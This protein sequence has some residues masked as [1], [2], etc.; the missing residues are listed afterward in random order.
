MNHTLFI[1][2]N[3]CFVIV[4]VLAQLRGL[5]HPAAPVHLNE[6]TWAVN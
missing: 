1:K 5:F 6:H 4:I 3:P 2:V